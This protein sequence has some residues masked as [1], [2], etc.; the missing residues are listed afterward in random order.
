MYTFTLTMCALIAVFGIAAAVLTK[1]LDRLVFEG[2]EE[3]FTDAWY[4]EE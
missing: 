2:M 3:D 1:V 4:G